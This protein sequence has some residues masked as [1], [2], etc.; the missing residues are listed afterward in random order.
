MALN[1][2]KIF[3]AADKAIRANKI[4]KAIKEYE[5]WPESRRAEYK[6]R[7]CEQCGRDRYRYPLA[8]TLQ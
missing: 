3:K 8:L 1:K 2:D 7:G 4:E 6:W 5:T